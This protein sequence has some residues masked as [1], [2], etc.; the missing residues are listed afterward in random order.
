VSFAMTELVEQALGHPVRQGSENAMARCPLHEDRTPSLSVNLSNGLWVC[1]SCGE[2]GGLAKLARVCGGELD[3]A[4]LAIRSARA[5]GSEAAFYGEL[6]D[7]AMLAHEQHARALAEQ[8][9]PIVDYFVERGLH[10]GVFRHF[11]LGWDGMKIS[12]PFYD[13][14]KVVG[15]KY[16]YPDGHKDSEKGSRRAIYNIDDVRGKPIVILCEGESD[17]HAVWSELKRRG[18]GDEVAVGGVPGASVSKA[19]VELWLLDLVWARRVYVLFDDD[20]AGDK[21]ARPFL[22]V[23]GE[24]GVR[25]RP[26]LGNDV[27]EHLLAGGSLVQCGLAEADLYPR[28]VA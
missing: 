25:A 12:Q 14:G 5:I 11:R 19:Q 1:F 20:E 3:E 6:P 17:T 16:R 26:N 28:M 22:E 23:L 7:F 21:G 2:K 4:E 8:P 9:K 13:D 27:S 10:Q 15:I 24:K 18:A